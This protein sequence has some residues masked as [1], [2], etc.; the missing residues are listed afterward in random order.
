MVE[1]RWIKMSLFLI[2]GLQ[3]TAVT[4]LNTLYIT[5]RDG[6]KVTLSCEDVTTDQDECDR[7][8]WFFSPSENTAAVGLIYLGQIGRNVGSKSDRLSV[9]ATCSLVIKKVTVEDVGLYSCRQFKSGEQQYRD[10]L[11]YLSV[12]TMT[13]HKDADKRELTCSV[14]TYEQCRHTVKW[15]NQSRD[16]DKNHKDVIISEC[17]S[18][19]SVVR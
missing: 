15:V 7:T 10:S 1:L 2:L 3:F 17:S 6:G 9:T 4:G 5:V 16:V 18:L 13:E 19:P 14:S 12:V 8:T 11:V